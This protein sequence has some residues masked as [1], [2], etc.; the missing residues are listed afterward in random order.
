MKIALD[1][2]S[3]LDPSTGEGAGIG[4]YT[5][6]IIK[7][8]LSM[9][10]KNE[11]VL[12]FSPEVPKGLI[13]DLIGPRVG[14]R[15]KYYPSR[16]IKKFLP[17]IYSHLLLARTINRVRP[18]VL[19]VPT[20]EL[21]LGYKGR[22]MIMVHDL[23][24]LSH[25][26]WFSV[27]KPR[28]S[29]SAGLLLSRIIKRTNKILVPSRSTRQD[30][31]KYFPGAEKKTVVIPHGV[32]RHFD[33]KHVLT[34]DMRA[35]WGVP[36]QYYLSLCTLEPRKNI[37]GAVTGFDYFLDRYPS[38]ARDLRLVIAGKMGWKHDKIFAAIDRVNKKWQ[39]E[40]GTDVVRYVG[41]VTNEEK[42]A[43]LANT[44]AFLYPSYYEGFGLPV[45]EAMA[46]GAPV[47][48]SALTSLP[49]VGG[50][51]VLYADPDKPREITAHL[52]NLIDLEY[53]K[54]IALVG[55]ERAKKFTWEQTAER[56]LEQINQ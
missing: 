40:A 22:S 23:A 34:E 20:H 37:Q 30:L 26:E 44:L 29:I 46:T 38:R 13:D 33:H 18:D 2:R 10:K 7:G 31:A 24:I 6:K 25:P 54:K 55:L 27:T 8:L 1:C 16:K 5:T 28:R 53:N 48:T 36:G 41:Y 50:E 3:V 42:W 45:L 35:K 15:V 12:F 56:T 21:P 47:I 9:D 39:A 4:H 51:A 32:V 43:L 17:F 52:V 19:F 11:Y 14:V 49:E